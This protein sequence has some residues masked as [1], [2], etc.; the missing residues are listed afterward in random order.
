MCGKEYENSSEQTELRIWYLAQ[1]M[2]GCTNSHTTSKE[3]TQL[4]GNEARDEFREQLLCV[5]VCTHVYV[6]LR[7]KL[8]VL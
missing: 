8:R 2:K 7:L 3:A 6:L 4:I 5:C 1:S